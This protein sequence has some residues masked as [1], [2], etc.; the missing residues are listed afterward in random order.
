MRQIH[1]NIASCLD[2]PVVRWFHRV[3][4]NIFTHAHVVFCTWRV[5]IA[6]PHFV[7]VVDTPAHARLIGVSCA[8]HRGPSQ[9]LEHCTH[10]ISCLYIADNRCV[11]FRVQYTYQLMTRGVAASREWIP[12]LPLF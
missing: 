12:L 10:R 5:D 1:D 2:A 4:A 7:P 9:A 6:Q 8:H 11:I 3:R